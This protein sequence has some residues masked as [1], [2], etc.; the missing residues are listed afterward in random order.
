MFRQYR[1]GELPDV[2]IKP[3]EIVQPLQALAQRDLTLAKLLFTTCTIS[4]GKVKTTHCLLTI[5]KNDKHISKFLAKQLKQTTTKDPAFINSLLHI[6]FED[7]KLG[8][9]DPQLVAEVAI[10]SGNYHMAIMLLEKMLL[11]LS[12]EKRRG[13]EHLNLK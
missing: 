7:P 6:S 11:Q 8:L 5:I 10:A 2:R 12:E 4:I 3:S 13:K 1:Q 9:I